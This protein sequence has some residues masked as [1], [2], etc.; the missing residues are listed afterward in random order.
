MTGG[1]APAIRLLE[2]GHLEIGEAADARLQGGHVCLSRLSGG[3]ALGVTGRGEV[4]HDS[5][6]K[7][8]DLVDQGGLLGI[9][10]GI[11]RDPRLRFAHSLAGRVESGQE[12]VF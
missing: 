4:T 7:L 9:S 12:S 5:C 8:P 11:T 2:A 1:A 3:F 6:S 10:R